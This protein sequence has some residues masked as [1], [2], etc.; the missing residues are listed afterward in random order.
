MAAQDPRLQ[1][2]LHDQVSIT[3]SFWMYCHEDLRHS[4]RVMALWDFLKQSVQLNQDLMQGRATQLNY[5][6]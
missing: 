6:P 4:H 3:R 1:V 2:V 5:L